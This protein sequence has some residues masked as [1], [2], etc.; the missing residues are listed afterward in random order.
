MQDGFP[1]RFRFWLLRIDD[2][3]PRT[4]VVVAP[5]VGLLRAVSA[6]APVWVD[7]DRGHCGGGGGGEGDRDAAGVGRISGGLAKSLWGVSSYSDIAVAARC[8]VAGVGIVSAGIG[9]AKR[10]DFWA[11]A[12]L[13]RGLAG[14]YGTAA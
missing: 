10:R 3:I 8:V 12:W 11:G 2:R 5:E 7:D 1:V 13:R 6:K 4:Q 9:A 14:D